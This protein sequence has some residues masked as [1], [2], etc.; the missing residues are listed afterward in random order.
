MSVDLMLIS[1]LSVLV[2]DLEMSCAGAA[3]ALDPWAWDLKLDKFVTSGIQIHPVSS[4]DESDF[5]GL[6]RHGLCKLAIMCSFAS[7]ARQP[8]LHTLTDRLGLLANLYQRHT[9]IHQVYVG[10]MP[11]LVS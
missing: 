2:E 9:Q 3:K 1:I 7:Q 4:S 10:H 6:S 5:W 8:P 11:L